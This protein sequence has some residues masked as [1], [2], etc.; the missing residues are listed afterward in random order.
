MH[1]VF[2]IITEIVGWIQIVLSPT[3]L[4]IS[5]G[6]G[7]YYYF[8]NQNG[9]LFGIIVAVIGFIIGL[10]WA[11]KKFKTTGTIHFLSRISATSELD[12]VE[13]SKK[14]MTEMKNKNSH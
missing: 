11:T 10:I 12:N 5:F 13:K 9:M 4:G 1:K 8:P 6:F 7:I 3:L 2:E 14:E